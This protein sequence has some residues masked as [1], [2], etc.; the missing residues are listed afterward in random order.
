MDELAGRY[1]TLCLRL[2][3]HLPGLVTEYTG[4]DRLL[5][6]VSAEPPRP[7]GRLATEAERLVA[8]VANEPTM[9]TQRA[10][11]FTAQLQALSAIG[12]ELAGDRLPFDGLARRTVGIDVTAPDVGQLELAAEDLATALGERPGLGALRRWRD[13]TSV[14][15]DRVVDT[16][17]AAVAGLRDRVYVDLPQPLGEGVDVLAARSPVASSEGALPVRRRIFG[18]HQIRLEVDPKVPVAFDDLIRLALT[19]TYPGHHLERTIK[20]TILVDEFGRMELALNVS[21]TPART[22][23]AG[24]ATI[25]YRHVIAPHELDTLVSTLAERAKIAV[26]PAVVLAVVDAVTRLTWCDQAAAWAVQA[27]REDTA[28]DLLATFDPTA[29]DPAATIARLR[30]RLEATSTAHAPV[31]ARGVSAFLEKQPDVTA[32]FRRLLTEQLTPAGLRSES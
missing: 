28:L 20:S 2:G 11:W 9:P 7:P 24:S 21:H 19:A 14:P 18:G 32:G 23:S 8:D 17:R 16:L 12:R 1:L 5:S 15:A 31:G 6:A 3:R 30:D 10:D 13:A 25:A 26:D 4:P 27:G 22:V 29:T